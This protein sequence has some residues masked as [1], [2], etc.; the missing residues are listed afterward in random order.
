MLDHLGEV[1][2]PFFCCWLCAV[3]ITTMNSPTGRTPRESVPIITLSRPE[4]GIRDVTG[5]E[6]EAQLA[7]QR[8]D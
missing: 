3:G 7:F 6:P 1:G 5:I 2:H 8:N 4:I